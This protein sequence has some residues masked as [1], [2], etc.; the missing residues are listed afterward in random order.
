MEIEFCSGGGFSQSVGNTKEFSFR[1]L[2]FIFENK[3]KITLNYYEKLVE[4]YS[5]H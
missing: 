1:E 2:K 5:I 4:I 3:K